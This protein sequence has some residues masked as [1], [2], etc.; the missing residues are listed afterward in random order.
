MMKKINDERLIMKNLQNIRIAYIIQTIG[1]L[2][3]LGYVLV[4]KGMDGMTDNPVWYVFIVTAIVSAYL[5]MNVN[6]DHEN[7]KKDPK[8]GLYLSILII[9]VLSF[10]IGQLVI[11]TDGYKL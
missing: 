10:F 5:S 4:T 7:R 8:K 1:I 2:G 6:V 3:I 11:N 9:T